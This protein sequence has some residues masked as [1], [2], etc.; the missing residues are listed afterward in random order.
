MS[1]LFPLP[2][3]PGRSPRHRDTLPLGISLAY[4]LARKRF[5][6]ATS[7]PSRTCPM[8][9]PPTSPPTPHLG[10]RPE[11]VLGRA[12]HGSTGQELGLMF[13]W[14]AAVLLLHRL[15]AS[16]GEDGEATD[17]DRRPGSDQRLHTLERTETYTF[18]DVVIPPSSP[19]GASS[20][21]GR[22][23]SQGPWAKF[24][25]TPTAAGQPPRKDDHHVTF[26]SCTTRRIFGSW[27]YARGLGAGF[28]RRY[29]H[30][31][32][33]SSTLSARI[34]RPI[35]RGRDPGHGE[36]EPLARPETKPPE[37]PAAG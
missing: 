14:Y 11:G 4:V 26:V 27:R 20:P 3:T 34:G 13:T 33:P 2:L 32:S 29:P 9:L 25:A 21:V 35:W 8:V 31:S 15:P 37:T 18:F 6:Y 19:S 23:R 16:A 1:V 17:G 36:A 7:S 28:P 5:P 12:Y 10:Y 30:T 24:G 22:S